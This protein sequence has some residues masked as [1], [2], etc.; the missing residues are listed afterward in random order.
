ML[1]YFTQIRSTFNR[2]HALKGN[3]EKETSTAP[4]L[5]KELNDPVDI[6]TMIQAARTATLSSQL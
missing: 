5:P 4:T 1:L 2:L 3:L 6:K